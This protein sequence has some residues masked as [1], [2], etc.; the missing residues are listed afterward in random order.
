[1]NMHYYYYPVLKTAGQKIV[2]QSNNG[3][4]LFSLNV[5]KNKLYSFIYINKNKNYIQYLTYR[6]R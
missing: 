1:M 3:L 4:T 5:N 6:E 2:E